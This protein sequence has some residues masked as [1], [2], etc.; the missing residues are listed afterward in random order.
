[1]PILTPMPKTTVHEPVQ[2]EVVYVEQ[3]EYTEQQEGYVEQ[4]EGYVE[5]EQ[6][7]GPVQYMEG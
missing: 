1:M 4:H 2:Q 5:D 7:V 3:Q 6:Y